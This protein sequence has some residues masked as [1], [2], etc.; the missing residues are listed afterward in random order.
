MA[1]I[2]DGHGLVDLVESLEAEEVGDSVG[3]KNN[4]LL[5][6]VDSYREVW[7]MT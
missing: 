1:S 2:L 7:A 6:L 3:C 5:A 4:E